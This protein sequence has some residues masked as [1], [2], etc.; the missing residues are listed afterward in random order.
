MAEETILSKRRKELRRRYHARAV[1]KTN[2][3][4]SLLYTRGAKAVYIFG[5]LLKPEF[6]DEM[7][8]VDIYVEGLLPDNRKGLFTELEKIF[9]T[10]K[11]DLFFDDDNLRPEIMDKIKK[12]GIEWKH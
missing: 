7:S 5:S 2:E 12:E 1:E 3:A 8:D 9:E 4:V 10:I 11:F 6:F